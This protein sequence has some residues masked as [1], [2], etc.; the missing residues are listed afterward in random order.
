MN[1]DHWAAYLRL[2]DEYHQC[3][4]P[5]LA[6]AIEGAMDRELKGLVKGAPRSGNLDTAIA[7]HR[8]RERRRVELEVKAAPLMR[9]EDDPWPKVENR[10]DLERR[11]SRLD[12]L[13]R[14]LILNFVSGH[15]YAEL[16]AAQHRPLG[17]VKAQIHRA[18]LKLA[19]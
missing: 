7:N 1:H 3:R 12:G 17:T 19:A 6:Q 4:R 15:T 13:T 9:V 8:R 10:L 18:R 2:Q 5:E 11:L 16:A 14:L